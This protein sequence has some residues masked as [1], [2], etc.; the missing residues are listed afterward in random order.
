[1]P[2]YTIVEMMS[3]NAPVYILG[4]TSLVTSLSQNPVHSDINKLI[5]KVTTD[6]GVQ[7]V[8]MK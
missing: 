7:H 1:M 4:I 6:H 2:C 3:N 5:L 8:N